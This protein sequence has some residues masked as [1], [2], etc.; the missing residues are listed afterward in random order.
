MLHDCMLFLILIKL[1]VSNKNCF[2]RLY[3][4][5]QYL[6]DS[7]DQIIDFFASN[8]TVSQTIALEAAAAVQV[9][10]VFPCFLNMAEK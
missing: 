6:K 7:I 4:I 1:Y 2:L 3:V 8:T 10:S 5:F 9:S